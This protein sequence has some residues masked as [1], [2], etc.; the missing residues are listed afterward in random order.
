MT[1]TQPTINKT[2]I[3]KTTMSLVKVSRAGR[4]KQKS[5]KS[6]TASMMNHTVHRQKKTTEQLEYLQ[7]L[8]KRLGG[9]W[10]T[11]IKREAMKKTGLTRM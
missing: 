3:D 7:S 11:K 4:R 2:A 6:R 1:L 10:S 5:F 9:N 8:F